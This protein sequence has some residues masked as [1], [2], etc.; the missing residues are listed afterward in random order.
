M[1][2]QCIRRASLG[3]PVYDQNLSLAFG[4][5]MVLPLSTWGYIWGRLDSGGTWGSATLFRLVLDIAPY[6]LLFRIV[7]LGRACRR[8]V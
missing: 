6:A 1:A 4:V 7:A 5:F 3:K 2:V 8:D